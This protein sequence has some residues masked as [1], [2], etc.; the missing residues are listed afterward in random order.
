[1][2]LYTQ[3]VSRVLF[4]LHE[5]L[6]GHGTVRKRQALDASQ[7]WTTADIEA[8]QAHQLQQFLG[9]LRQHNAY[10]QALFETLGLGEQDFADKGVLQRL[11]LLDKATIRQ[12]Q[13]EMVSDF[14]HAP[15]FM[16]TS[17]SSGTPLRF[18]LGKERISHDV[19]AKW[20]ATRWWGVD[21]GD[22]EAV[23]WGSNIE[24]SGQ[25]R[26]KALRDKL[27]RSR[28]FPAKQLDAAGMDRLLDNLQTFAPAMIYGYPS[29]LTLLAEHARAKGRGYGAMGLKVIFCT[30]EKLYPHQRQTIEAFFKAPVA[31]GY[32]SRDAGF[33]AHECP[34]GGLHI[35]AEDI[36]TE[37]LDEQGQRCQPGM[38]GELVVTHLGTGDFPMLRYRTG[39]LAVMAEGTC[40]CGRGLPRFADVIGRSNDVLRATNGAAVH[41]AYIGNIVREDRA[42]CHFQ[43]VQESA[44]HF[45]LKVV[46]YPGMQVET[47]VLSDK[48]QAVLGNEA[49]IRIDVVQNIPAEAT[50]KYKYIINRSGQ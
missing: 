36:I 33:I 34:E 23:I 7:W 29:I 2:A 9:R 50:G 5:W 16:T 15:H 37:V 49:E 47:A 6:K 13:Q 48:L 3:L 17:G 46:A 26:A 14:C 41:G 31:N 8:Y 40:A 19:A 35:S 45:I 24:L 12:H 20:R 43:L 18:V 44:R 27:F 11:P 4:P 25:G 28:L 38:V 10:Y 22:K 1:M 39:D 21:I 32:G 30:A 42:V